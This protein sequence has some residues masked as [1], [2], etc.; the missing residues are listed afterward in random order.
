MLRT[1]RGLPLNVILTGSSLDIAVGALSSF[2]WNITRLEETLKKE[3]LHLQDAVIYRRLHGSLLDCRAELSLVGVVRG[4][5]DK[6]SQGLAPR[7]AIPVNNASEETET[8]ILRY[9]SHRLSNW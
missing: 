7:E 4:R 2:T 5:A 8:P 3:L 6:V 1:S 9:V